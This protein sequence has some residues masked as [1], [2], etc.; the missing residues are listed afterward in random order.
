MVRKARMTQSEKEQAQDV[1]ALFEAEVTAEASPAIE[2]V[3]ISEAEVEPEPEPEPEPVIE[4]EPVPVLVGANAQSDDS[5]MYCQDIKTLALKIAELEDKFVKLE[6]ELGTIGKKGNK[7]T[8]KEKKK[9]VKCKC[10]GK[11]VPSI[12][13]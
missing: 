13:V 9:K 3:A 12:E 6:I 8:K 2:A 11:K 10:K 7:G 4:V 5:N 1:E